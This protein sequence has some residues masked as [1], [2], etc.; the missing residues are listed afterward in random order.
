M[1]TKACDTL[2][3]LIDGGG[4]T[5]IPFELPAEAGYE[6]FCGRASLAAVL[7]KNRGWNPIFP[8]SDPEKHKARRHQVKV[9]SN[10]VDGVQAAGQKMGDILPIKLKA[11]I[12]QLLIRR[13]RR[14]CGLKILT[15]AK[16]P[17]RGC[18]AE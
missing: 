2:V 4:E 16:N 10:L 12:I 8:S 7:V 6:G 13:P 3:N 1:S 17:V 5:G 9:T 14:R 15:I 11:I 18:S